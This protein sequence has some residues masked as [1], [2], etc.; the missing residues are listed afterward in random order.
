MSTRSDDAIEIEGVRITSPEKVLYDE[1]GITKRELAEYYAAIADRIVEEVADRPLTLVRCP[2]GQEKHCFVQRRVGDGFPSYIHRVPVEVEG[3][4]GA[5]HLAVTSLRGILYLVQIGVLEIH[6]WGARRDRLDRPDRMILDLDPGPE[7]EWGAVADAAL[8]IRAR[9]AGLGL[10][11]WVKTTGG[12]G[13]HVVTPLARTS[14]WDRVRAFSRALAEEMEQL[15]PS[16]FVA[17]A[18]KAERVGKVYVD[19]LRN[20]Y[21]ATAVA[22]FSSRSREGAPVSTPIGWE[23]LE[24]GARPGDFTVRTVPGRLRSLGRRDPWE[25]F[26]ETRQGLTREMRGTMGLD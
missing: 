16:R 20:G 12:K 23:E 10:R 9:L 21:G 19:Y 4:E 26:R 3:E 8:R 1:Q 11:S 22:A 2:Q 7:V 18:S 25:G 13:L 6:V 5:M 15:D 14:T 17:Q 24:A